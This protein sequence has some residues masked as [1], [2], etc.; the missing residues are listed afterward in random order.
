MTLQT[1]LLSKH[2]IEW[3]TILRLSTQVSSH[4]FQSIALFTDKIVCNTHKTAL[5]SEVSK[6]GKLGSCDTQQA[7]LRYH[8]AC[9][10]SCTL[11]HTLAHS[12]THSHTHLHTVAYSC[13]HTCTHLHTLAS[14]LHSP[15]QHSFDKALKLNHRIHSHCLANS[16]TLAETW[17]YRL[18]LYIHTPM[19][20]Q[21]GVSLKIK[22]SCQT[23]FLT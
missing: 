15:R 3:S 9:T 6:F 19:C 7:R 21:A 16:L 23:S 4:G 10:H 8:A 14:R 12:C 1:R 20:L 11:L 2:G 18:V 5:P 13:T 17:L 22:I